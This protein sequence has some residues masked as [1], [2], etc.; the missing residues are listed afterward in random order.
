MPL[1]RGVLEYDGTRYQGFQ[2]LS[3]HPTVQG[4]IEEACARIMGPTRIAGAGRTDAG[5]HAFGQV[6]SF[7]AAWNRGPGELRRALNAL[8]PDDIVLHEL[9]LADPGFHARRDAV[10]RWYRYAILNRET[11]S[12]LH[13]RFAHHVSDPLDVEACDAICARLI[14][15]HDF[16]AFA[17][18]YAGCTMRTVH[19]AACTRQ[20]SLVEV[21]IVISSAFSHLVRRLVGTLIAVGRGMLGASGFL[22]VLASKDRRRAAA[23]APA[24]GLC[25]MQ[26]FY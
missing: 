16:G 22:E 6:V 24:R 8:L 19:H 1:M 10:G 11:R 25:L 5:A 17:S 7:H 20:G 18:Q 2:R 3:S 12:P 14:G 15:T 13:Q 23:P 26:V 9:T 4:T 21:D